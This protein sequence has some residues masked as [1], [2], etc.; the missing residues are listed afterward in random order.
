MFL[1]F[2]FVGTVTGTFD[3]F[4]STQQIDSGMMPIPAGITIGSNSI[5]FAL[6]GQQE[7]LAY[8]AA[9]VIARSRLTSEIHAPEP[10]ACTTAIFSRAH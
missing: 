3:G 5:S 10:A 6:D 8:N 2:D 1:G 9:N 4:S 7:T